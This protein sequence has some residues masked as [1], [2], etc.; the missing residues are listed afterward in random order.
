MGVGVVGDGVGVGDGV[1]VLS[2]PCLYRTYIL[3]KGGHL[4]N[5]I[6]YNKQMSTLSCGEGR[7]FSHIT[8]I[9]YY[10]H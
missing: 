4:S 10:L 1:E 5:Y 7:P 8:I 2:P 3:N 9:T 6:Q